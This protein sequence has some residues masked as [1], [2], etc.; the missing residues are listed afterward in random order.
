MRDDIVQR[1][2]L[3]AVLGYWDPED[4][5]F[6]AEANAV[7]AVYDGRMVD[8]AS[9]HLWTWDARP[10]PAFPLLTDVWSDG[11]NWETGHWLNG[12]LGAL[13]ADAL[14]AQV[15]ADYGVTTGSGARHGGQP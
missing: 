10:Y 13:T 15:L 8:P 4:D 7:S 5:A 12:R 9:I 3:A 1:R 11:A 2:F 14:V 6:H